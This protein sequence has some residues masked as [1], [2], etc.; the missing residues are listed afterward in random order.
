[1]LYEPIILIL[2]NGADAQIR[3]FQPILPKFS[4]SFKATLALNN[5]QRVMAK[6]RFSVDLTLIHN[7]HPKI[8]T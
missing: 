4:I 5:F 3:Q 2:G 7:I 6:G 8:A 1:M